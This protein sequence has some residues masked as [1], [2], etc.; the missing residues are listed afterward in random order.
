MPTWSDVNSASLLMVDFLQKYTL[1]LAKQIDAVQQQMEGSA[2]GVMLA[3]QE[4]SVSTEKKKQ[5]AEN[6]LEQ[7][8]FAPDASTSAMVDTIQKSTDDIFEQAAREL[9][10]STSA[11]ATPVTETSVDR[12]LD[13]RRMGGLFSKHMESVSTLDDSVKDIVMGMVGAMSNSDVVKQRLD[14]LA[15]AMKAMHVGL[16]N[17]LVD[18]E[19]R[20][21]PE[22]IADFKTR[23]LD[24][25]YK[26]Y[27]MEQE[28]DAFKAIFGASPA[29]M[30]AYAASGRKVG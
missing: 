22:L 29:V 18:L 28:K 14:H 9:S 3:L 20:L 5:E 25:T 11:G 23:L 1:A 16:S 27:T 13:M 30:K 12:G 10:G 6:A 19:S 21:T 26:T 8:Y 17:I 4:L 15:M 2:S 24:Y 7:T